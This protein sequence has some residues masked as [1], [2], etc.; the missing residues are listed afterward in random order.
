MFLKTIGFLWWSNS[1]SLQ[2]DL[3]NCSYPYRW[4][5]INS[6]HKYNVLLK[7]A[8]YVLWEERFFPHITWLFEVFRYHR[9]TSRQFPLPSFLRL[10]K[11][12]AWRSEKRGL[13]SRSI[14]RNDCNATDMFNGRETD[15]VSSLFRGHRTIFSLFNEPHD[16]I[17]KK[18][19]TKNMIFQ[20]HRRETWSMSLEGKMA[21]E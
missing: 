13:Y 20:Y 7:T 19:K 3:T 18:E 9:D 11:S 1:W 6:N 2:R 5:L 16:D 14:R 15:L 10:Y 21:R 8:L 4:I 12:I 17:G